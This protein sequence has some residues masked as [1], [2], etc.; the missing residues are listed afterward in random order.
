[1]D[2]AH[3]CPS[4]QLGHVVGAHASPR[5][6]ADAAVGLGDKLDQPLGAR[7]GGE[8]AARGQDPLE[9]QGNR[10]LQ[11]R[12]LIGHEVERAVQGHAQAASVL[13]QLFQHVQIQL[14]VRPVRAD[15]DAGQAMAAYGVDVVAHGV[16]V[17]IVVAEVAVAGADDRIDGNRR[18]GGLGHQA[19]GGGQTLQAQRRAKFDPIGSAGD[20]RRQSGGR[21]DTDFQ[22][23][24]VFHE[25][26]DGG[27]GLLCTRVTDSRGPLGAHED[28]ES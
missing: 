2:L 7:Q 22:E 6:D 10:G 11:R 25:I 21:I 1:M 16:Q 14:A 27:H 23:D 26:G 24:A 15:R 8:G 13:D 28:D 12:G 19:G 9:A 4:H 5:Q 20:R 18:A 17:A 3:A